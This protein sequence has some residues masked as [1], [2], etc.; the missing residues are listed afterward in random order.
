M[1]RDGA[2]AVRSEGG[3]K[4]GNGGGG[5]LVDRLLLLF[6]VFVAPRAAVDA[7]GRGERE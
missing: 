4:I 2:V 6:V 5:G 1:R 3:E 7:G